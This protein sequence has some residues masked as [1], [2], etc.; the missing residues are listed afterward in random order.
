MSIKVLCRNP[1]LGGLLFGTTNHVDF[2]ISSCQQKGILPDNAAW[3]FK[4]TFQHF[5][6]L[7]SRDTIEEA[8]RTVLRL[9]LILF[10]G[11]I[12]CLLEWLVLCAESKPVLLTSKKNIKREM[13]S[14]AGEL[15][16][17]ACFFKL[18]L[19]YFDCRLS[20][21]YWSWY[22]LFWKLSTWK[23]RSSQ[24]GSVMISGGRINIVIAALWAACT[25]SQIFARSHCS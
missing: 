14:A 3:V 9:S 10:S 25:H 7:F 6:N 21:E 23:Q 20:Q 24:Y 11:F 4:E 12:H 19:C 1:A 17:V 16:F 8:C 15:I 5:S 22:E 13:E 18:R 2:Q